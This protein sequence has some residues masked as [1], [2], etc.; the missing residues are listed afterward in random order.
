MV[1]SEKRFSTSF[2]SGAL[3]CIIP[4]RSWEQITVRAQ[5]A[6]NWRSAAPVT[7]VSLIERYFN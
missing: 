4:V 6:A 5:L 7:L 3:N 1:C 2:V